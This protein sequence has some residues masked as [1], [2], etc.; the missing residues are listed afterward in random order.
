M[1]AQVAGLLMTMWETLME[2]LAPGSCLAQLCYGGHW[3]SEPADLS[4]S[5]ILSLPSLTCP[6]E[7]IKEKK[8]KKH[9]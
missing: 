7:Q 9:K 3:A 8:N 6:F 1:M 4:F 2:L 5:I